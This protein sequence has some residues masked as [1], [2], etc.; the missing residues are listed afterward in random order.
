MLKVLLGYT[1]RPVSNKQKA[2]RRERNKYYERRRQ[3]THNIH[4]QLCR[5]HFV[6]NKEHP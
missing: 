1:V 2:E 3:K 6:Q 5:F 4:K